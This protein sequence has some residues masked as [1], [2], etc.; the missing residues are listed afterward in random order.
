MPLTQ[1]TS[2]PSTPVASISSSLASSRFMPPTDGLDELAL[3]RFRGECGWSSSTAISASRRSR[4]GA[5]RR[6]AKR[7]VSSVRALCRAAPIARRNTESAGAR[8]RGLSAL[9]AERL[10]STTNLVENLLG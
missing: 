9:V 8:K 1:P 10:A 5:D 7:C 3:M 6:A 2:T 4:I